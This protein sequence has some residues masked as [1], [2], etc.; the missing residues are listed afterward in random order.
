MNY[1]GAHH[2]NKSPVG[3]AKATAPSHAKYR[4]A[5]LT[6]TKERWAELRTVAFFAGTARYI[7]SAL[8]ADVKGSA[9]PVGTATRF[10]R[11]FRKRSAANYPSRLMSAM[12]VPRNTNV[13]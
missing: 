11:S 13:C 8:V 3:W 5:G 4:N 2:C 7:I 10:V 6:A 1:T 12:G 9:A